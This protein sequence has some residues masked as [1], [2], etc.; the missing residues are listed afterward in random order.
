MLA[1]VNNVF[2]QLLEVI[3]CLTFTLDP[4]TEA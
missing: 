3:S 1:D 4:K 2:F